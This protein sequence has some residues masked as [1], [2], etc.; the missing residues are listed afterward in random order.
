MNP[1]VRSQIQFKHPIFDEITENCRTFKK[2]EFD[3][4]LI[5]VEFDLH[6]DTKGCG[7][8]FP[9]DSAGN[10]I[11][12]ELPEE[13]GINYNRALRMAELGYW[14]TISVRPHIMRY[15]TCE[16]G[17]GLNPEEQFDA[18]GIYL[19]RACEKCAPQKLRGYRQEVLTNSNYECDEL[20]ESDY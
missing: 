7:Y 14:K 3:D 4:E 20:I 5:V 9:C 16:C 18:R 10:V 19:C 13:A 8:C 12:E 6:F 15:Q 1:T 17:S 2:Q 11:I